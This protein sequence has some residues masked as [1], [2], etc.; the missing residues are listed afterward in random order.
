MCCNNFRKPYLKED[1]NL[2]AITFDV[3]ETVIPQ[4]ILT[5]TQKVHYFQAIVN[6]PIELGVQYLFNKKI[7]NFL[8]NFFFNFLQN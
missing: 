5:N 1:P 8:L 3:K 6:N 7:G 2:G 4:E